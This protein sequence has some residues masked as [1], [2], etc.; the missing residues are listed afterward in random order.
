MSTVFQRR[1]VIGRPAAEVFAWHERPDA[2]ARLAPPW[3]RIELLSQSGGIRDGARV[4]L[5][6]RV[7]PVWIR[8]DVRHEGYVSG[9]QFCDV[10][11]RGPFA[12]WRHVHRVEPRGPAASELIDEI[13]YELPGGAPGR[14]FGGA[15]TRATLERLFDYRHATTKADVENS[16]I[17]SRPMT[18]VVTGSTGLVGRVLVP[19]LRTQG[20][21]VIR[22]V[23]GTPRVAD[24][25]GWRPVPGG[26]APAALAGVDAVIHLAGENIAGGRW[27]PAR[28]ERIMASRVQSTRALVQVIG[29]LPPA[30]RPRVLLTSSATGFYGDTGDEEVEEGASPGRG[31]LAEVCAAWEAEAAAVR[32]LGVRWVAAR[33]GVVLTPAGG[34]LA[35]LLPLFQCGLGGPVG[36]GRMWMSWISPDD[37]VGAMAWALGRDDIDGAFNAVAPEAVT[38]GAFTEELARVLHR[39]AWVPVPAIILRAVF[40]AM[41]EE[42]LLAGSRVRPGRLLACGYRFRHASLE[43]A[44]RHVLGRSLST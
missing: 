25:R 16:P 9:E 34:A 10:Q 26:L 43:S 20:H 2:F 41:A 7:G 22:L 44:L 18:I 42:T 36:G 19:Y 35:K 23:R 29:E 21:T 31:F 6:S 11:E 27:T 3:E 37:L 30:E 40:G 1:V 13:S 39:P 32:V 14:W 38:N 4:S 15:F 28:R 12:R 8:W 24:E 17:P 5:R 33:T